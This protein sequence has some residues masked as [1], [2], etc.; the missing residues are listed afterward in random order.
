V[1]LFALGAGLTVV[2]SSA[3]PPPSWACAYAVERLP[4]ALTVLGDDSFSSAEIRAARK[5]LAIPE[6]VLTR[7]SALSIARSLGGTRLVLIRCEEEGDVTTLEAQAFDVSRPVADDVIRTARPRL[8]IAAAIDEVARRLAA[9]AEPAGPPA[10]RAPNPAAL[11]K[12]GAALLAASDR[13]RARGLTVALESDPAAIGL[14]LST[15]EA[16][17]EARNFEAAIRISGEPQAKNAPPL[18]VRALRFQQGAAQ[19]E[20]GRYAEA[21]DTFDELVRAGE[22]AGALNN[23]GVARFRMRDPGASASFERAASFADPRQS[24]ISFNRC[25]ALVFEGRATEALA[26]IE[27]EIEGYPRDAQAL[28]LKV[29]ALRLLNRERERAEA[30]E[31][32]MA[33]AP[34]FSSLGNPDL[35]RRLE[36][37]FFSERLR[38][39]LVRSGGPEA[40]PLP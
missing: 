37:V 20:A 27:R 25:L 22:T 34:S 39:P 6:P 11:T 17:V 8:E 18:L 23:L 9:T 14:R 3:T 5:R 16:L 38:A 4:R 33:I 7:A 13:E 36:R 29:W 19:L 12:A 31:S 24:D 30:W 2:S 10:F 26:G 28:L 40:G 21:G 1:I 32:L 15:V 35:A